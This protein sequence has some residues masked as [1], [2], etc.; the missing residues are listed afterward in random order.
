MRRITSIKFNRAT[1]QNEPIPGGWLFNPPLCTN[2]SYATPTT[3]G[4]CCIKARNH[5]TVPTR[6]SIENHPFTLQL[7]STTDSLRTIQFDRI[8]GRLYATND[9]WGNTLCLPMIGLITKRDFRKLR[10]FSRD[11]FVRSLDSYASLFKLR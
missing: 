5:R 8:D 6:S 1:F 4:K 9:E 2:N 3:L 7:V 10:R 11:A